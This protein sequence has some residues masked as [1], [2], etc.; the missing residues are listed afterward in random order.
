MEH[1]AQEVENLPRDI[2]ISMSSGDE[3]KDVVSLK[4]DVQAVENN[5]EDIKK[6]S[7]K[8][9]S[10]KLL[11]KNNNNVWLKSKDLKKL[12]TSSFSLTSNSVINWFTTWAT[13]TTMY[14]TITREILSKMFQSFAI[15]VC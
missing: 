14:C 13:S 7:P 6:A 15:L 4:S 9:L 3:T 5:C 1:D 11:C 12:D 2:E 8:T 10:R